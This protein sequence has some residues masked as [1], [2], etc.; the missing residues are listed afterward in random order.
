M[1]ESR[2][3]IPMLIKQTSIQ[4]WIHYYAFLHAIV[5]F[6]KRN[7]ITSA[8]PWMKLCTLA[9]ADTVKVL[10]V[11]STRRKAPI[12][13][14]WRP[15][16]TWIFSQEFCKDDKFLRKKRMKRWEQIRYKWNNKR[17]SSSNSFLSSCL[18]INNDRLHMNFRQNI[19]SRVYLFVKP[20]GPTASLNHFN[21]LSFQNSALW[22]LLIENL[23][24]SLWTLWT[25]RSK[26]RRRGSK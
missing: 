25:K 3:S 26:R 1:D 12:N 2:S 15:G 22:D 20:T 11:Q 17:H 14:N 10:V 7:I 23:W 16:R 5:H 8:S 6:V 13:V 24:W 21:D 9:A 4:K 18:S 19:R